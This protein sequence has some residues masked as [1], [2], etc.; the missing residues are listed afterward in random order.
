MWM[1]H[2]GTCSG[3]ALAVLGDWVGAEGFSNPNRS[4]KPILALRSSSVRT[5]R[6]TCVSHAC[7]TRVTHLLLGLALGTLPQGVGLKGQAQA[8]HGAALAVL[9]L[10]P[11]VL[12]L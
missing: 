1:W 8:V 12:Q 11:D 3:V 2:L 10:Q 6:V 7:H 4:P 9:Q 5:T